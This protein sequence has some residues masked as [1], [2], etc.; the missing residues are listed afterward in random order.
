MQYSIERPINEIS[1]PPM[2][3]WQAR[4]VELIR[5]AIREGHR[6]IVVQAPTGGGKTLLAGHLFAGSIA[7]GLRPMFTVPDSLLVDQTL[8]S[9]ERVGIYDVGVIQAQHERTDWEAQVQIASVQTLVRRRRPEVNLV[10]VD[11]VHVGFKSFYQMLSS[12]AWKDVVIIGLSATPWAK[13]MAKH[14]S[15]LIIGAT[16][17]EL[18]SEGILCGFRGFGPLEEID[19]SRIKVTAG[20]FNEA[21]SSE[22]MRQKRILGDVVATWKQRW[23][24]D[25]T[26]MFCVDRRHAQEQRDAFCNQGIPFG[27]IDG[28]MSREDRDRE[29]RDFR[30]GAIKGIASVGCLIR[31]V[32]EDVRCISDCQPTKSEMRHAQKIGRG[33]R[34]AEGKSELLILDHAGNNLALG[35]VTDI[36]HDHLDDGEAGDRKQ[37]YQD[38]KEPSKPRKCQK[39]HAIVVGSSYQ[40]PNC[41]AQ[42]PHRSKVETAKGELVEFGS[43]KATKDDKQGFYSG[44]LGLAWERRYGNPDGWAAHKYREKYGVWPSGLQKVPVTPSTV[45]RDFEHKLRLEWAKRS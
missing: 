37:P 1:L 9:F 36:F 33:L 6:R 24:Q 29:F 7:K 19:R 44:L 26:F 31:G 14:W 45:V 2:R 39:C 15:K 12:D 17:Q 40:C 23:G 13:G 27:Y 38:D 25:R 18:I 10:M 11:E 30:S 21:A 34:P 4:T 28:T 43:K 41:G 16:I 8:R 22:A 32:D 5:Q 20:E 42:L 3:K 35:T